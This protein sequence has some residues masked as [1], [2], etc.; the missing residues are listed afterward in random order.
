M[1]VARLVE[2]EKIELADEP[3]PAF[4]PNG[5]LIRTALAGVCGSDVHA[6]RGLHPFRHPPVVLGHELVGTV[7]AIGKAVGAFAL[8]DRVTAM[9]C[10]GCGRCDLCLAGRPNICPDKIV[11]GT[12]DWLGTFGEY[13]VC[14][15]SIVYR[16][17]VNTSMPLGA[18]AEPLAVG[19]HSVRIARVEPGDRVLV[20]GAGTIGL[21]TLVAAQEAGA[22]HIAI[23]DLL[24]EH[25]KIAQTLGAN[26]VY[27]VASGSLC[28]Q[29]PSDNPAYDVVVLT[30]GV[31]STV[32]D[33]L[34][35]VRR[36]GRVV[37][38]AMFLRPVQVDLLAVTLYEL[39]VLGSQIYTDADFR[40][41]MELLDS[42]KYRLDK[43]ITHVL[44]LS[45]AQSALEL[46]ASHADGAVKVLLDTT[47]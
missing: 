43:L 46:A 29:L 19:V 22:A 41:A 20:L 44:P 26:A 40:V 31:Q 4:G 37:V 9:P 30:A 3:M 42:S 33:A 39:Q 15:A 38:T 45:Q 17:G 28:D 6:F 2:T 18:L 1:R 35:L 16:L 32:D 10:R 36:G 11:P 21:L 7:E 23:T 34:K 25:L 24:P 14:D 47:G 13:C 12:V 8:G 5:V 27:N